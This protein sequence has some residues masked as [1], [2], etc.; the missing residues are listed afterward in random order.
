M[1]CGFSWKDVSE[2]YSAKTGHQLQTGKTPSKSSLTTE[3]T[4][5]GDFQ[6]HWL[7]K[8]S[9]TTGNPQHRGHTMKAASLT[10][11]SLLSLAF[12]TLGR[13]HGNPIIC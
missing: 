8:S 10:P 9:C 1:V 2:G 4:H 5:W 11:P 12:I 7:L 6:E 13:G 3:Q